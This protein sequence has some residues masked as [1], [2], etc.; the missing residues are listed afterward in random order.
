[1]IGIVMLTL[2]T[3]LDKLLMMNFRLKKQKKRNEKLFD[4]IEVAIGLWF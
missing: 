3:L 2:R 4:D 1:M